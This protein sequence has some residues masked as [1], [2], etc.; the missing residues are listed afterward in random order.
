[1][2]STKTF[3]TFSGK[4]TFHLLQTVPDFIAMIFNLHCNLK[5]AILKTLGLLFFYFFY[6]FFFVLAFFFFGGGGVIVKAFTKT[7]TGT[8]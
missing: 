3:L 5:F 7:K 1:M 4:Y 2:D 8:S 6:F